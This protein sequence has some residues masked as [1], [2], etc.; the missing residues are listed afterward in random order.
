MSEET[1]KKS[2]EQEAETEIPVTDG[3]QEENLTP[4][5]EE[6]PEEETKTPSEEAAPEDKKE[7]KKTS[8]FGKKKKDKSEQKVEELTDRLKRTMAE[9][10]NFRKRTE[11]EKSSMYIIGAKEIVEK[12][13]PVVDNFERG[14]AQAQEGDAFADG[15]KMIYKQ[16]TTTLDELGVKPIEAVGKEFNPD[17]HNAVMHVE[18]EEVGENIV[19]EEFQKGYTY[20]DFVVRHSMVKVAN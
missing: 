7:E 4:E 1:K 18:D 13:L 16:L 6:L 12:I 20:K 8:F 5:G 19:V 17:F 10:D 15:M 14:L 3:D 2:E 11:K 9:F